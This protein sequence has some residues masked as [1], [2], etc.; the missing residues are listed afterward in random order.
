MGQNKFDQPKT[1]WSLLHTF[2]DH[3]WNA[4]QIVAKSPGKAQIQGVT[5]NH[6]NAQVV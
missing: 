6:A 1:V 3:C 2:L 5:N 4:H